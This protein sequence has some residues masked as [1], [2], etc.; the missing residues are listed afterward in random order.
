MT[1]IRERVRNGK[2]YYY[3]VYSYKVDG[4]VKKR[5]RYLGKSVPEDIERIKAEFMDE[6]K[7]DRWFVDLDRIKVGYSEYVNSLPQTAKEK[8]IQTFAT[9]FTYN[10]NRIEGSRLT[11]TE[12]AE[13]LERGITPGGRPIDDVKEAEAHRDAFYDMLEYGKDL[14]MQTVLYF[15]KRVFEGTKGDIAGKLR[16]HPVLIS[17]SKFRPPL[18]VEVYPLMVEFFKW[19]HKAKRKM[20]PVEMAALVHLRLVTIHPFTDGNGRVSRLMMN[21]VL[22]KSGF[23][24]L[25]IPYD[26]RSGYYRALERSQT[27]KEETIFLHW[28]F[29]RYMAQNRRYLD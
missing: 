23:P 28:F 22:A 6:V 20:H 29:R 2:R 19:Y 14:S 13:L 11:M 17:G 4:K 18:P 5:E 8:E 16:E 15:H 10:T 9:M 21:M 12:T 24:M 25:D 7:R 26:K 27:R 1:S 3:L